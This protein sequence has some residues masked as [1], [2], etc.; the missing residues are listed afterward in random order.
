MSGARFICEKKAFAEWHHPQKDPRRLNR[1][2][3]SSIDRGR[4]VGITGSGTRTTDKNSQHFDS[5][6]SSGIDW[7][8][9]ERASGIASAITRDNFYETYRHISTALHWARHA[10]SVTECSRKA[11]PLC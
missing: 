4:K 1:V 6:G 3:A 2:V 9:Q 7:T 11:K 8:P 5:D 10:D